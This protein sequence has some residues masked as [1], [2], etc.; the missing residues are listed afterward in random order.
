MTDIAPTSTNLD[1]MVNVGL[2]TFFNIARLWKLTPEQE[3]T[4]LGLPNH[5]ILTS[6]RDE[7]Y[8]S[9]IDP[10]TIIRISYV[11]GIYKQ[12]NTLLPTPANADSWLSE[13]NSEALFNGNS[14]LDF[15]LKDPDK[16]LPLLL[17]YL[18]NVI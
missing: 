15:L 2:R 10:Q 3:A 4:L 13:P 12:L 11:L 9:Q 7:A 5:E 14:A 8:L 18:K 1:P 17:A 16:H 6:Q